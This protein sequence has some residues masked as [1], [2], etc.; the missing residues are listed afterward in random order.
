MI[1]GILVLWQVI[2][3]AVEAIVIPP[4]LINTF[5]RISGNEQFEQAVEKS[6]E[7]TQNVVE[8]GEY[9]RKI[10]PDMEN[11]YVT[12]KDVLETLK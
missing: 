7:T 8:L 12:M 5:R 4:M 11:F 10:S 1:V 3:L 2:G 6:W 9:H